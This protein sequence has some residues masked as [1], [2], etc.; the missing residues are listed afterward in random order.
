MAVI[1]PGEHLHFTRDEFA[2]RRAQTVAELQ[3][4]GLHALLAGRVEQGPRQVVLEP[5]GVRFAG[6]RLELSVGQ[7]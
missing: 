7:A 6:D 3:R 1:T 5:V 2:A 4:R